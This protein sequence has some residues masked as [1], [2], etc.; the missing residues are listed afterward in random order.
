M[1]IYVDYAQGGSFLDWTRTLDGALTLDFDT[2]IPG[3]GPVS[4]RDDVVKFRADLE[5]MRTRL[6]GLVK[7]GTSK[8]DLRQDAGNRL[9][10]AGER[11][12][13]QPA[14]AG[15]PAVPTGRRDD[16]G[17]EARAA[18]RLA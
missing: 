3:H 17:V 14:D 8:D 5:T 6:A 13:S 7:Q 15:L 18:V 2:V 9:R 1:N 10:L 11:L 4:T 16:R 12:S